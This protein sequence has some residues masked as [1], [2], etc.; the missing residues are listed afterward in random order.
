MKRNIYGIKM[1]IADLII[2]SFWALFAWHDVGCGLIMSA[3]IIMRI[4][5]SF[6]LF[7]KSR[8][9]LLTALMFAF[10]YVGCIFSMPD[11]KYIDEPITKFVYVCLCLCGQSELAIVTF[12]TLDPV[13]PH[14]ILWSIWGI[15]SGWLVLMPIMFSIRLNGCT[16]I[17]LKNHRLWWYMAFVFAVTILS[18][19]GIRSMT[20]FIFAFLMTLTPLAYRMLYRGKN[21]QLLQYVLQDNTL[22]GYVGIVTAIFIAAVIGLYN[23]GNVKIF[24]SFILPMV[25]Y[26]IANRL[27]NS[28][29][30]TIPAIL[31]GIGG[32]CFVNCYNRPHELVITWLCVGILLT[33]V[34]VVIT[35]RNSRNVTT[36]ILLVIACGFLLP[37]LLLGYNPYAVINAD[38][39]DLIKAHYSKASNG[40]YEFSEN[41]YLGVRDRYG[42][43][44]P[45]EYDNLYFL[46]G[47]SDYMVLAKGNCNSP[48][49]HLQVFDLYARE[50]VIPETEY[51]VAEIKK[52]DYRKYALLDREGEQ[53]FTL[54]LVPGRHCS[55]KYDTYFLY[56][57]DSP[58][59]VICKDK[60]YNDPRTE[61][62]SNLEEAERQLIEI[63][64]RQEFCDRELMD[65]IQT[66]VKTLQYQFNKLQQ[67]TGIT[68]TTS[69]D[70]KV[71]LYS[72]D[73]GLGGTSP[74]FQTYIQYATG[75]TVL[76]RTLYPIYDT[77]Y[78]F[79]DDIRKDGHEISDGSFCDKLYQIPMKDGKNA[80]IVVAYNRDSSVE[81]GQ[82]SILSYGEDG[83]LEKLPF[84]DKQGEKQFS[85]DAYYYIPDWYFTTDGL[86]WDWVM[87]FDGK[88]NT[89]YVP[90]SGDMEMSDRYDLYRYD[91]G[92]MRY[93]GNDAGY[94]LHPSLKD[95]K[96][97]AGI[98][99]TDTKLIRIDKLRDDTFR[100]A[101]WSKSK[102]MSS[103]P[104]LVLQ[105]GETGIIE[106]AIVF[107]N[108]DYTYIVPEYRRGQG[109]DFDKVIV[110]Y[111]DRV[112]LETKV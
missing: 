43:V 6:E 107:R 99:Q 38:Y 51:L 71:R 2:V 12:N 34:G 86:G 53:V 72:W 87:S 88:T 50:F 8:W 66:N 7:R 67:K 30:R 98:Y 89:L 57:T 36:S 29:I 28:S 1:F 24:A 109:H 48:D 21:R 11:T 59:I 27:L 101:A 3:M 37:V 40:L 18:W 26:I 23:I 56:R 102:P 104:E 52:I 75:D 39:V 90:E 84:V 20:I 9:A 103:E 77:K 22:M 58:Y 62:S 25:L 65:L 76:A 13:I 45:P 49:Y 94:W 79:A 68:I 10:V 105:G 81:G 110:K 19:F 82:E 70:N 63:Y 108:G 93:I 14:W 111:K 96:R 61:F 55:T 41:G 73:T 95:F 74:E 46:E 16:A 92:K 17:I 97:L 80:Y 44:V 100:Y 32:V 91:D 42:I 31:I 83:R 5:L 35:F 33:I 85:A 112:I 64:E 54:S 47:T 78:V 60:E 4:S 15:I 106:N 69:P